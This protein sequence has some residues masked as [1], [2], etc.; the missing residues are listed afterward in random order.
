M[1]KMEERIPGSVIALDK[2][3]RKSF[4]EDVTSELRPK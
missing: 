1:N 3:I 2:M 4:S